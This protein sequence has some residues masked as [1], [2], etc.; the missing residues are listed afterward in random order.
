[1]TQIAEKP[2]VFGSALDKRP[3]GGPRWLDD[4][5]SRGAAR[6]TALGIPTVR[7]EEWR[8]TNVAP[9]GAID[10]APA[11]QISG[12]VERLNGFAYTDAPIRLVIVNGR[13]DTTLSRVKALPSGVQARSLAAAL[14]DYPDV[15]QRY[16][17]QL[18]DFTHRGFTAL[19]T[20]FV[21][22]GAFIHI[23]DGAILETPIHVI[24]VSGADG[25]KFMSHPRTLIVAGD[26]AQASVIES[27]IGAQGDTYFTNVVSEIFVGENAGVDHYKVQA[28]SLDAFHIASLHAHTS[29]SS[30]FSSHSFALGGKLA[31]S[32]V[33]AILDGEG[34]DCTLNGLYLADRD[35]LV[36]NHTSI[37][38][39]KPHCGSHEVYK[40]I[41]GGSARAVFNGKIIVRQDAQKTDAKQTNR[42]LL[43]TDGATINTKPQL[44]IFAD[45][46]KCTHGAAIGQLDEDAIFYLR[47][48]GLTYAEARDM[49]IHAF[50]GQILDGVRVE[51]LR[52]ALEREL[53]DQLAADLADADDKGATKGS[54]GADAR[55]ATNRSEPRSAS[56]V[57][58]PKGGAG[59]DRRDSGGADRQ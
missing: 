23:P 17:G 46:V 9:L 18:A 5:R 30:R 52:E 2:S 56:V 50:A 43:L 22:D 32:D 6:F 16:F 33:Y 42:A 14:G 53:F 59:G 1:M 26:G 38:H 8:F 40:G 48:R 10:F 37:D 7:D 24:F 51:P 15:V 35:R 39:A 29:R 41:L 28:E 47:T 55:S 13:F 49:L 36:D 31:R 19:N 12:A 54:G 21:Q 34:G 57:E 3:R 27:Y 44:E 25:S 20:A 4:L 11:E 58:E 45:D